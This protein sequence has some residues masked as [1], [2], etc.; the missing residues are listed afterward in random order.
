M[1]NKGFAVFAVV[2]L[3][4]TITFSNSARG[5]DAHNHQIGG[6]RFTPSGSA[7]SP[8]GRYL[9]PGG[10][11]GL[12]GGMTIDSPPKAI[13]SMHYSDNTNKAVV[14]NATPSFDPERKDLS[15]RW[16][17]ITPS[18]SRS[19]LTKT[20]TAITHFTPDKSG[21]YDLLLVVNDGRNNS[22]VN[23]QSIQ[24]TQAEPGIQLTFTHLKNS[25]Q[26]SIPTTFAQ[27]FAKGE[28]E[29]GQAFALALANGQTV[30]L[31]T[32]VKATYKDGSLRHAVFSTIIPQLNANETIHAEL[33]PAATPSTTAAVSLTD[34]LSSNF[35]AK[36]SLQLDGVTY[37][38]SAKEFLQTQAHTWLA[39][40]IANE[41][42]VNGSFNNG[43]NEHPHLAATFNIR[44]YGNLDNIWVSASI[45][46]NWAYQEGPKNITYDATI[47]INNQIVHSE[48]QLTHL[49]NARWR[50]QFWTASTPQLHIAHDTHYLLT[51]GA[52]PNYDSALI[53]GIAQFHL[54]YY[55]DEWQDENITL[56]VN[57][58]G[59]RTFV[60]NGGY[61]FTYNKIGPMGIGL[62]DPDMPNTG[63][64]PDIGPLPR[65][66]ATYLLS[67][68]RHA[69]KA[70]IGMGN[71][72]ASWPIHYR[73]KNTGLPLSIIDYPY[74]SSFWNTFL[75]YNPD[76]GMN[77]HTA[78]CTSTPEDCVVPYL[79]DTAHQP[80]LAYVP[81]LVTGDHYFL[82]ELHFWA[83][84]NLLEMNPVYRRYAQGLFSVDMQ[85]R[86]QAWSMRTLGQTAFITPDN[87]PMKVYFSQILDNNIRNYTF[88]Y[89]IGNP[90][91]YGALI[92]NYSHPTAS[93][94]MDDFFT[95]AISSLVDLD[96][97]EAKPLLD[98]KA[99]FS[100]QRMGFGSQNNGDYCWIFASAYHVLIAPAENAQMFNSIADVYQN[101]NGQDIPWG[102]GF[103]DAGT[104]CASEEQ[105]IALGLQA[106]EMIGYSSSPTGFPSNLQIALAAAVNSGIPNAEDAWKR[107]LGRSAKPDYSYYPNYAIVPRQ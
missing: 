94:W 7:T 37:T 100:V 72:A 11:S 10:V 93:P 53:N 8:G 29:A 90:N 57:A 98:W 75:S 45:E 59:Y 82:E 61:E 42:Y 80:S 107:F 30:N 5:T 71:Q 49:R 41:W 14:A 89:V 47:S 39:G 35:D 54:D 105:A 2:F 24:I 20:N 103:D 34:L 13:F 81:Y 85:D 21:Q 19:Q 4:S 77:E 50:K 55:A 27:V 60:D 1:F 43:H 23:R 66:A 17:L 44:S 58:D 99:Q 33:I 69:K 83:N 52:V 96:F 95:W 51:T 91:A 63:A 101:T 64:R 36:I 40:P 18:G 76:T 78:L 104:E 92:P 106:G 46:N 102:G 32:D 97:T 84:Y 56:A 79:P 70:A 73:D 31:Q 28:F 88:N 3:S 62:A 12:G 9:S 6:E 65:W 48:E 16:Q 87:H 67:Q 68:D 26:S 86:A 15:Y 38:A 74:A 25:A 22:S